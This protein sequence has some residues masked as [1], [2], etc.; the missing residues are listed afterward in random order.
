[1]PREIKSVAQMTLEE[2]REM[3]RWWEPDESG[4]NYRF[5]MGKLLM[6]DVEER[7]SAAVS[8]HNKMTNNTDRRLISEYVYPAPDAY[9]EKDK[10]PEFEGMTMITAMQ[11]AEE[12][13]NERHER[14]PLAQT[15]ARLGVRGYNSRAL[16]WEKIESDYLKHLEERKEKG[17]DPVEIG[18][19]QFITETIAASG[20]DDY[21]GSN[22]NIAIDFPAWDLIER[23]KRE[24]RYDGPPVEQLR[25][26]ADERVAA[27]KARKAA[28][29]EL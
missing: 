8:L 16:M 14:H 25:R 18:L 13:M 17:M 11:T 22:E 2:R 19:P 20:T 3:E 29:R 15:L 7:R 24:N 27:D 12:W 10:H 21:P 5:L 4:H 1:M 28:F 26:E 6:G 23:A 9:K